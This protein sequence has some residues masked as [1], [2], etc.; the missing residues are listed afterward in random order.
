MYNVA[1]PLALVAFCWA[2]CSALATERTHNHWWSTAAAE[3]PESDSI[4]ACRPRGIVSVGESCRL[5]GTAVIF[6]VDSLR[7][8]ACITTDAH[9]ACGNVVVIHHGTLDRAAV[10]FEAHRERN[11]IWRLA[12]V[13]P[14]P[15]ENEGPEVEAHA[16]RAGPLTL[17]VGDGPTERDLSSV[18]EDPEQEPLRYEAEASSDAV[19]VSVGGGTLT[20]R[21]LRQGSTKVVVTAIDSG[22]MMATWRFAVAVDPAP[23]N[24]SLPL[25]AWSPIAEAGNSRSRQPSV[26]TS[27]NTVDDV[28]TASVRTHVVRTL[29]TTTRH[30]GGC[31]AELDISLAETGLDCPGGWIA[32]SCD[33]THAPRA[34]ASK[35]FR[36]AQLAFGF[37]WPVLV[38]LTDHRKHNGHCVADRID[39]FK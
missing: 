8:R 17:N 19:A 15:G 12:V 39:V 3:S 1:R 27:L 32:F 7:S 26:V 18:F 35:M 6:E 14:S 33:G 9:W 5:H 34:S 10:A 22:G 20:L 25:W 21:P 37:S 38:S 4:F 23:S 28:R 24:A 16:V 29:A 13:E 30:H 31:M 36:D 2:C 11:G